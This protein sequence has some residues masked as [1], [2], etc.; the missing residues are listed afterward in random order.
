MIR[1]TAVAF[2]L[3]GTLVGV[4]TA[5]DARCNETACLLINAGVVHRIGPHRINVKLARELA[6]REFATLRFDLSGL[7]DSLAQP[8]GLNFA[9]QAVIDIRAAMDFMQQSFG[10]SRFLIF[11]ICSGAVNAFHASLADPR[12]V[13]VAMLD[14]F[15]Y[16]TMWTE[17]VRRWRRFLELPWGQVVAIAI[18]Q[19]AAPLRK[20]AQVAPIAGPFDAAAN[21]SNPPKRDFIRFLHTLV[22]RNTSVYFLYGGTVAKYY[23]YASQFRHA[24]H[25]ESFLDVI[26]CEYCPDIDHTVTTIDAQ[27]KLICKV[28]TWA[29]S[30]QKNRTE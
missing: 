4:A 10:V 12:I 1:E 29:C 19:L 22:D 11:G 17:P 25:G 9:D 23:S 26:R 27:R 15:W 8:G 3:N 13:G 24:F 7:G 20:N 18:R 2:G 16:R 28:V 21:L 5:T 14:G 6:R 30:M